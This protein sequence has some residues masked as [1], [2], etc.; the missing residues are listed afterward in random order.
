[1]VF[2]QIATLDAEKNNLSNE[3]RVVDQR[4]YCLRTLSTKLVISI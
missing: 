2:H 3:E 4:Q 1:M